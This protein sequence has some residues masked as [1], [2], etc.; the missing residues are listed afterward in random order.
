MWLINEV[1]GTYEKISHDEM[2]ISS[3]PAARRHGN[4]GGGTGQ[5][6]RRTHVA[7]GL[8]P[9]RSPYLLVANRHPLP[10]LRGVCVMACRE[11]ALL[12]KV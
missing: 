3:P 11:G 9:R 6:E 10:T 4:R 1:L 2:T 5:C 8:I 7:L 12:Y